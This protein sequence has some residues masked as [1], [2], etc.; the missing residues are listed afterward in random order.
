MVNGATS[1]KSS[2]VWHSLVLREI[3]LALNFFPGERKRKTSTQVSHPCGAL[4]KRPNFSL[5][6]ITLRASAQ[7]KHLREARSKEKEW[8]LSSANMG[9]STTGCR[10][11]WP[12]HEL[13]QKLHAPPMSPIGCLTCRPSELADACPQHSVH[14]PSPMA[15][16]E[17]NAIGESLVIW[18][19][20]KI[21]RQKFASEPPMRN[22]GVCNHSL[23]ISAKWILVVGLMKF[24]G[25]ELFVHGHRI[26]KVALKASPKWL[27]QGQLG[28][29]VGGI[30][31]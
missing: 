2:L 7:L 30:S 14:Y 26:T 21:Q 25:Q 16:G 9:N 28:Q 27:L 13:H 15:G 23:T 6:L 5:L 24:V 11:Y 4:P 19:Y 31:N 20:N 8:G 12:V 18:A 29:K 1:S 22:L 3:S 17:N 10:S